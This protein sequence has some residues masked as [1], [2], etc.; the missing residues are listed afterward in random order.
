[1][2]QISNTHTNATSGTNVALYLNAS[3]ATTANYGLIVNAGNVGIGTTTPTSTLQVV[4]DVTT[5]STGSNG[6]GVGQL[7]L[8]GFTYRAG[9]FGNNGQVLFYSNGNQTGNDR[10]WAIANNQ[11]TNGAL[12]FYVSSSATTSPDLTTPQA[13]VLLIDKSGNVGIGDTSPAALLTVGS[14]DLFQVNS[15]GAIAAAAGITSSGTITLSGLATAGLVTNTSAGVLGTLAGTSTT[16]LHGN[17]SGLPTYGAIALTTDVSG[18]L[19]VAN[20]GTGQT[21]YTDGQLLIGNTTGNTLTKATLTGTSNQVVVTNGNGTITLSTPQDIA[22]S[23]NVQFAKVSIGTS[24]ASYPLTVQSTGANAPAINIVR[25]GTG[26]GNGQWWGFGVDNQAAND[27]LFFG[28]SSSTFTTG[29]FASWIGNSQSFLYYPGTMSIGSGIGTIPVLSFSAAATR[30]IGL[31]TSTFGTSATSNLALGG[32]STSPVLG[33][34]TADLVSLAAVDAAAGDRRLYIQSESGSA[35]SLGNDRLN[36]AG[37]SGIISIGGSDIV[38]ISSSAATINQQTNFN[39][40]YTDPGNGVGLVVISSTTNSYTANSSNILYGTNN[41]LRLNQNGFNGTNSVASIASNRMVAFG[42][43]ASGTIGTVTG[44]LLQ[45]GNT[46]AGTVTTA[47]AVDI[48]IALN[49]GGGTL[50]NWYGVNVN[51]STAATNNY[52]FRGQIASGTTNYNLYMD[53]TAQNYFAGN[54]GIGDTSPASLL[55]VGSG[56]L[57]QVNSSGAIA[58]AAGITSSGTITLSGLATAG[59]VTNTSAGVLGT[60]AGTSTTV[61]HGNAS[62]LPTYGAVALTTD[63]SGTL[64][65]G[66][67]GTGT[68]TAFTA[69]SVIFA[70]ASGVYSQNNTRLFWDNTNGRLGVGTATPQDT[71]DV[72]DTSPTIR[73]ASGSST[74]SYFQLQ[75][76]ATGR[77]RLIKTAASGG[78]TIDIDPMVTDG[79]SNSNFRFFRL[80]TTSGSTS[81]Q[82]FKGDGTATANA[83]ISGN[84]DSYL[85]SDNGNT[86]IGTATIPTGATRNIIIGGGATTPVLGAATADLVSLAA[87][88]KAAGDRRLYIQS[89]SGSAISLGNDRLNFAATTGIVSIAGTD[90][91]SSTSSAMTDLVDFAVNGNTTIGNAITDTVTMNAE[92]WT[93]PATGLW[94][95]TKTA[96]TSTAETLQKYMVSDSNS[97]FQVI[98]STTTDGLFSPQFEGVQ[99]TTSTSVPLIFASTI[100]SSGDTGS[101]PALL[102]FGRVSGGSAVGTRPLVEFRNLTT[103]AIKISA[104]YNLQYFGGSTS[105]TLA[106]ATADVVSTAAV[107]KA[108]GDRRLYIQSELGS[109]ISLGNDRL[110]FAAS[111][112]LISIAGTD[113]LSMT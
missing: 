12:A 54:V 75:D 84:G 14:G 37:S 50:T 101:N 109:A 85:S 18:T 81:F 47:K 38:T 111:T 72:Y 82:V 40:V 104:G 98:N 27:S 24:S 49:S 20:G 103:A 7:T 96:S 34:A 52:G 30:N 60:L 19:P 73:L 93:F 26:A 89:E 110:N 55:S 35:I 77:A 67:G 11:T 91:I 106:G 95:T 62:G 28:Y 43:G 74:T 10:R 29:G 59:L 66:N 6:T 90:V 2:A 22:T 58:A 16:V 61:L 83:Q 80:V 63:V 21:T 36:F 87:V 88:D 68:A 78:S 79:I 107:D 41:D 17:A 15:S 1:G 46:G 94:T 4:G 86:G 33:A 99:D 71:V 32:G 51:A 31:S 100:G 13:P 97:Y 39:K 23:S 3:G 108:A 56:D 102:F 5:G 113:L 45:V 92:A 76:T 69:G 70:G 112:G 8:G 44:A 48:Q 64:P 9:S 42:T 105:P 25:A 53:G 57:F 65:V